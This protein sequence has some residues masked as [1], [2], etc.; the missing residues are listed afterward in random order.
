[1]IDLVTLGKRLREV[2][3]LLKI[4]QKDFAKEMGV[5]PGSISRLEN[6]VGVGSDV[7]VSVL[8][9]YSNYFSLDL[10]FDSKF[11]IA[12]VKDGII[13]PKLPFDEIALEKVRQT[14]IELKENL[15]QME[16]KIEEEFANVE[17]LLQKT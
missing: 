13:S 3:I 8:S 5:A 10:I 16:E 15:S 14:K 17:L 11:T 2:R 4:K 1:M 9:F 7:L 6:G 12:S